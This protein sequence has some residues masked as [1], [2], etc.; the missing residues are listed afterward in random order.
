[1]TSPLYYM[2]KYQV[3]TPEDATNNGY[4]SLTVAYKIKS[5]NNE[6]R[7]RERWMWQNQCE[8]MTGTNSVIVQVPKG[9]EMWRHSSEMDIDPDSGLKCTRYISANPNDERTHGAR[10]ENL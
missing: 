9:V 1:M 7:T 6:E 10:K 5:N 8:T 3:L 2:Y 4:Q